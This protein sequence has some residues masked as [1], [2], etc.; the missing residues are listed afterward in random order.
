MLRTAAKNHKFTVQQLCKIVEKLSF[1]DERLLAV[2]QIAPRF[3]DPENREEI[4]K[5]LIFEHEK[6]R[7][8]EMLLL[9]I[10]NN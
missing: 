1:A 9:K 7:I 5:Y 8:K 3:I 4:I 2:Q 10:K 6:T